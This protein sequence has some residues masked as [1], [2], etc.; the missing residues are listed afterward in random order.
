MERGGRV[1]RGEVDGWRVEERK[2]RAVG[3]GGG[4][5]KGRRERWGW[6]EGGK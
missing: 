2:D 6:M 4:W 3:M 1:E 5:K